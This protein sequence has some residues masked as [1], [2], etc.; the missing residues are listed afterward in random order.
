M[1]WIWWAPLVASLLHIFEEFV[2][3]GGFA[4]WDRA[5]RPEFN[6]SITPR[7]HIL[8]NALL[9]LAGLQVGLLKNR[10]V[11]LH[12]GAVPQAHALV[13]LTLAGLLFS[14]A[15]F[16]LKGALRTHRYSPGIITGLGLYIPLTIFG[17][18]YFVG[19]H[20]ATLPIALLALAI[21]GSYHF[22]AAMV[23]RRR[24]RRWAARADSR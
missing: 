19:T 17:Y 4:D 10:D 7:F 2:Y 1:T 15:L 18:I 22:W 3:P 13:W 23:H 12:G 20:K 8:V 21:G 14:N 11:G 5:Y 24:A 16:H 6:T 9:V